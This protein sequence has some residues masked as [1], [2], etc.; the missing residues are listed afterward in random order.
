MA[1]WFLQRPLYQRRECLVSL[2]TTEAVRETQPSVVHHVTVGRAAIRRYGGVRVRCGHR[3]GQTG[4]VVLGDARG[5]QRAVA[6]GRGGGEGETA[7]GGHLL[8]GLE[9]EVGRHGAV[10]AEMAPSTA[11]APRGRAPK[12]QAFEEAGAEPAD[13]GEELVEGSLEMNGGGLK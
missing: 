3:H 10:A 9:L 5:D 13:R 2:F 1:D 11:P 6:V 7:V 4:H 8:G 12:H